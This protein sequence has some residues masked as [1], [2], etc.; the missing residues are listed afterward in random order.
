[1]NTETLDTTMP[2]RIDHYI[3]SR[4][5]EANTADKYA[6]AAASAASARKHGF[7]GS[8]NSRYAE[9]LESFRGDPAM[10]EGYKER[11]RRCMRTCT[12]TTRRLGA[13]VVWNAVSGREQV[14]WGVV[15]QLLVER[16]WLK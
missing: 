10:V 6:V 13:P 9:F 11:R 3:S 15:L 16:G 14:D 2:Q 5:G 4:L 7:T 8:A 12:W 1:M